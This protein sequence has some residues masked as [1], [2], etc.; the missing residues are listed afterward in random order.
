MVSQVQLTVPLV[1]EKY[2][3]EIQEK[4]RGIVTQLLARIGCTRIDLNQISFTLDK[5]E[6]TLFEGKNK[7]LSVQSKFNEQ[8]KAVTIQWTIGALAPQEKELNDALATDLRSTLKQLAQHHQFLTGKGP[9]LIARSEKV[10]LPDASPTIAKMKPVV[11]NRI[12]PLSDVIGILRNLLDLLTLI[13]IVVIKISDS[14]A[15]SLSPIVMGLVIG[16]LRI[17]QGLCLIYKG[18]YAWMSANQRYREAEKV[19]DVEGMKMALADCM[20]AKLNVIMGLAW[21]AIG[22]LSILLYIYGAP[23]LIGGVMTQNSLMWG[24]FYLGFSIDAG[25]GIY[26]AIRKLKSIQKQIEPIDHIKQSK[27]SVD[28]KRLAYLRYFKSLTHLTKN[29]VDKITEKVEAQ[30]DKSQLTDEQVKT[31]RNK[32][33][34][35]RILEKLAKKH[36]LA[37]RAFGEDNVKLIE[38][39]A[40]NDELAMASVQSSIDILIDQIQENVSMSRKE[41][42]F[43]VSMALLC[44]VGNVVGLPYDIIANWGGPS[45]MI[46]LDLNDWAMLGDGLWVVVNFLYMFLD[47]KEMNTWGQKVSGVFYRMF[48]SS[49]KADR[50]T[51]LKRLLSRLDELER[52]K[53][54]ESR[55]KEI[56]SSV[57]RWI[58]AGLERALKILD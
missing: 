35:E 49:E 27:L 38:R 56:S 32:K 48:E 22:I 20:D 29:E 4:S 2:S 46:G 11:E 58:K 19:H 45:T 17:L 34:E 18:I 1:N 8:S 12:A 15:S 7:L 6:I 39:I 57:L 16:P 31:I 53:E 36:A 40:A 41:I 10:T 26:S 30:I 37:V 50:E 3:S 43:I 51:Y 44:L 42:Y 52:E 54:E 5:H 28:E 55:R 14:A 24:L 21:I 25:L 23:A 47:S 9:D 33:I 13:A